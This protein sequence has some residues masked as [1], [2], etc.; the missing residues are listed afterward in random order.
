MRSCTAISLSSGAPPPL[1]RKVLLPPGLGIIKRLASF[2]SF[3]RV[4]AA[5]H[6][7]CVNIM[8]AR[9]S[10]GGAGAQAERDAQDEARAA[11]AASSAVGPSVR[12]ATAP[13]SRGRT[14]TVREGE[15]PAH[16]AVEVE[17]AI[18]VPCF[19]DGS[20]PACI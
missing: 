1:P 8:W 12:V 18:E 5:T 10:L 13:R 4:A 19:L 11:P 7:E 15:V 20:P 14:R 16:D 2:L 3:K 17:D 9:G 6:C